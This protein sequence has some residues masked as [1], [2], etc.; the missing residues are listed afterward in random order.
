[1]ETPQ[2]EELL[3]IVRMGHPVLREVAQAVPNH[4]LGTPE[5]QRFCERLIATMF[6]ASGVGLAA[7]QVAEGLRCFA[8][9]VP[10]LEG[11]AVPPRVLINP[12]ITMGG[13][14][15]VVDWEGCLSIPGL[16]GRVPRPPSIEVTALTPAGERLNFV[17]KDFEARVI[18]HEFDHLEGVL[19]LDRMSDLKSLCFEEEWARFALSVEASVERD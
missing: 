9:F 6:D 7:P 4:V 10:G 17:A 3:K 16:R 19:Y 12:E 5:F 1:M 18:L 14:E 15:P 2:Q 11:K 13:D 8:Y